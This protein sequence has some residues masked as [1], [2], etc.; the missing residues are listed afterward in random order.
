MLL[1]PKA[2]VFK[3]DDEQLF[4]QA[5]HLQL[6]DIGVDKI[7]AVLRLVAERHEAAGMVLCCF[8]N[9]CKGEWCHRRMFADWWFERTGEAVDEVEEIDDSEIMVGKPAP[10]PKPQMSLF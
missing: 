1:A 4:R 3:I 10:K 5:Y 8:E 6:D 7:R 2:D 9:V